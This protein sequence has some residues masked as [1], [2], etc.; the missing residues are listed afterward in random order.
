MAF[1]LRSYMD[2]AGVGAF[3]DYTFYLCAAAAWLLIL[4]SIRRNL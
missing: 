3:G 2:G 4:F 1:A